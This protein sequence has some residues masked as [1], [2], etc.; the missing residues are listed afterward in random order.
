MDLVDIPASSLEP[1]VII[2]L[3]EV[4][5]QQTDDYS[6]M[7]DAAEVVEGFWNLPDYINR[8][9]STADENGNEASALDFI[10]DDDDDGDDIE[11]HVIAAKL[12]IGSN[13]YYNICVFTF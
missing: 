3:A 5:I 8:S 7:E 11:C 13:N 2:P 10:L 4:S 9:C 1:S 12:F 6:L